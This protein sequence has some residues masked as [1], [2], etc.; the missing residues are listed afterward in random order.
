M[1]RY[2]GGTNVNGGYYWD[3]RSRELRAIDGAHGALPGSER[4][5][6]VHVP[7]PVLVVVEP[8]M[9]GAFVLFLPFIE[10]AL[11]LDE[12][13]KRLFRTRR[14]ASPAR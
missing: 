11:A 13:R 9:G 14:G 3:L 5:R 4:G 12:V 8:L 1:K 7:L 2:D 6:F 10:L